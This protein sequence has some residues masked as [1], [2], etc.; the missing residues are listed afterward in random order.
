[1]TVTSRRCIDLAGA[2][3][4]PALARQFTTGFL[5]DAEN[6]RGHPGSP[7]AT[8]AVL[9]VASELVTNAVRHAPGPC[10]LCLA[11]WDGGVL[12]EVRDTS[13]ALPRP[14]VP[15]I[16]GA[17]GGWGWGLVNR[18]ADDVLVLSGPDGGKTVRTCLAW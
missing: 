14:R 5:A 18:L 4:A 11:T 3:D 12:I 6:S 7:G 1:M 10:T 8:D 15:D 9:L 16:T 17:L 13:A 2:T